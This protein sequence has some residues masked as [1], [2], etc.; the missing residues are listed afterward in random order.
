MARLEAATGFGDAALSVITGGC[1]GGEGRE[2]GGATVTWEMWVLVA[3]GL[4]MFVG[5]VAVMVSIT[6]TFRDW[7][8]R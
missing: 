4:V 6:G 7:P 2:R 1:G 8:R 5:Y 3:M